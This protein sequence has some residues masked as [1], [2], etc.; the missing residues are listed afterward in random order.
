MLHYM[1]QLQKRLDEGTKKIELP[2]TIV[3]RV[4]S[5][6]VHERSPKETYRFSEIK[7]AVGN[8]Q[9]SELSAALIQLGW[10]KRRKWATTGANLRAWVPP[11][12]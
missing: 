3:T 9:D 2:P 11:I 8:C 10:A 1:Q 5:W 4:T 7:D 6:W 12:A